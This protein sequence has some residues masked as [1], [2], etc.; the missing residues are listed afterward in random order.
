MMGVSHVT[1]S[2]QP[3]G[4][5]WVYKK[6]DRPTRDD[7]DILNCPKK[8]RKELKR[9]KKEMSFKNETDSSSII[10]CFWQHGTQSQENGD[11]E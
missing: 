6:R 11:F 1:L 9:M 5:L 2:M 8:M 3:N 10:H 7:V 4:D